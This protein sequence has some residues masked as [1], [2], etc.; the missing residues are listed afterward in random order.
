MFLYSVPHVKV[1]DLKA[2]F[3]PL[4][5]NVKGRKKKLLFHC[6]K[7]HQNSNTVKALGK[8]VPLTKHIEF[9]SVIT[10]KG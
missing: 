4:K 5:K 1:V 9:M 7:N 10:K 3:V 2:H 8:K 6:D